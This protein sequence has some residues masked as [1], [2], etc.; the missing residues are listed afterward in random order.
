M[1]VAVTG[2]KDLFGL[3]DT[4]GSNW[5]KVKKLGGGMLDIGIALM[6]S[7]K[8][9]II[10]LSEYKACHREKEQSEEAY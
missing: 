9:L 4:E 3:N 2:L 8:V 7:G 6:Q 5:D 10:D 1:G